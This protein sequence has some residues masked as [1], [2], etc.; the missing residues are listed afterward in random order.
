MRNVWLSVAEHEALTREAARTYPNETG[1][2]LLGYT[3]EDETIVV[4][5]IIGPG[6]NAIHRPTS[7][8]PDHTYQDREVARG[9]ENSGRLWTYLGDWHSHPGGTT[10]LSTTDRRTLRRIARAPEARVTQPLMLI[11][12]G[13]PH[14]WRIRV[15]R[16]M[17]PCWRL[18]TQEL[19]VVRST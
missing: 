2:I 17:T 12:A 7:F 6:P 11:V 13:K 1:G 14:A 3:A 19:T 9:Y 5:A 4:R 18:R 15:H 16:L 8:V 10:R